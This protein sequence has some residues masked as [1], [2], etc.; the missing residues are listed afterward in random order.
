MIVQ[1][2]GK[3]NRKKWRGLTRV[4]ALRVSTGDWSLF[5][6]R[7]IIQGHSGQIEI[8]GAVGKGTLVSLA[9]PR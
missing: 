6:S 3:G 5:S 8:H 7:Q 4:K 1:A 2:D 9:Q